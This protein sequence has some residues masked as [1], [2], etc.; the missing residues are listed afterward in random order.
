MRVAVFG[1]GAWGRALAFALGHKNPI[2]IVSRQDL[3]SLL[4]PL[5]K[6]LVLKGH[7]PI[8]QGSLQEALEADLFV[9]AISVQHLRAWFEEAKLP[10]NSRVLI[11]AKGIEIGGC[12]VS[13]IAEAF[14]DSQNI[15][16]LAG[17]SFAKEIVAS[18]PCALALHSKNPELA[19]EFAAC[20]PAFIRSYIQEDMRGAEIAGAYKNVIAIAAGVCD[21]LELGQGAKASLLSRGLV[22]MSRFG[23]HF[24]GKQ[25]TFLGLS[26]AGDLFLTA[27]SLLS[28]NYRVGLGIAQCKPLATIIEELQEVA[29]GI[30]TTKAIVQIATRENIHTPIAK[31]L[32]LLLEGKNPLESMTALI[33]R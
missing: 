10:K 23:A 28:R 5:N 4:M 13:Q 21:G 29:E 11:A 25:Q 12:F 14:L 20:L 3:T 31:E 30:K 26:G 18:L 8:T 27:N 19:Q 6:D 32:D 15:C 1:G 7:E 22:E 17:P 24:G 9:I 16:Y 33:K 2:K